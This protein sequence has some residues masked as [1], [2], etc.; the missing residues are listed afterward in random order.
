MKKPIL[1]FAAL[2][3]AFITLVPQKT[4]AGKVIKN[5]IYYDIDFISSESRTGA[6]VSQLGE[7]GQVPGAGNYSDLSGTVTFEESMIYYITPANGETYSVKYA[8]ELIEMYA[9]Q[10]MKN[11]VVHI[12]LPGT[13][14]KIGGYAFRDATALS[15]ISLNEGLT[16]IKTGA[17]QGCTNLLSVNIPTTLTGIPKYCFQ[18]CTSLTNIEITS[19]TTTIIEANAFEGCTNLQS[20]NGGSRLCPVTVIAEE[21]FLDCKNLRVIQLSNMLQSIQKNAFKNCYKL[22][23]ITLPAELLNIGDFAFANSGLTVLANN[24]TTPQI[25]KANVFNGVDLSK[26]T[27]YVPKGCKDAYKAADVWKN[28]GLILEPG[29]TPVEP[30]ATGTQKIGNLYYDLHEDMTA[31][32]LK[33][34]DNM[35]IGGYLTVPANVKYG[36]YTYTVNEMATNCFYKCTKLNS[37][38]LPNTITELE[39]G[40]FAECGNLTAVTLPSG[41]TSIGLYAFQNT[42]ITSV[43]LPPTLT[44]IGSNAFSG[45]KDLKSV[46]V[47]AGISSLPTACFSNCTSLSSV[48]LQEGMTSVGKW[49]FYNCSSLKT[50]K[51][52][53]TVTSLGEEAF[54]SC[55]SLVSIRCLRENPPTANDN[56]FS[57][58]DKSTCILYVPSGTKDA[59]AAAT[60][61]SKF[62]HIQEKGVNEKIKYGKLYYQ[63]EEDGTAYVT[64]ETE[65]ENNYKDLS[66]EITV[67]DKIVYKGFEYKVNAVGENALANCKGITKVNLPLIMDYIRGYAF[68]SCS[69]LAQINIP[70]TVRLLMSTAFEGTQLFND[71]IDADGAVYYDGC[72][73]AGPDKAYAGAYAVK[74]G[75]RLLASN[76]FANRG[77]ITSLT[78]PEGLQCIC[79]FSVFWMDKLNTLSLPSTLYSVGTYFG[80]HCSALKTIYNYSETPVELPSNAFS[81]L[82]K[83]NCTLYVPYGSKDAYS[84]ANIWKDF[85]IMEMDPIY[86]VTFEDY[87]GFE[88]SSEQVKKGGAAT[89]PADPTREGY[90][91]TGWD[92]KFDNVQSDLT[93]KAIYTINAY[94]VTFRDMNPSVILKTESVNY[95]DGAT[96]PDYPEHTGYHFLYWTPEYDVITSD[97]DVYAQYEMNTYTVSF[98]DWDGTELKTF[99]VDH[100]HMINLID[101]PDESSLTREC[102][103]F[104]G[105]KSSADETLTE[106]QIAAAEVMHDETYSAYYEVNTYKLTFVC[107]HGTI[108]LIEGA[109]DPDAVECG[110]KLHFSVTPEEG[111]AFD[112]WSFEYD[113][114]EGYEITD[115]TTITALM[116]ILTYTVTFKDWDGKVLKTETVDY[117]TGA[118]APADPVREG[119]TFTGWDEA[120]DVVTSDLTVTALYE[121][122]AKVYFTVT[123]YDWDMTVLGTEKVEEGHDAKG[124]E[125][126][127]EREGY[128]FTGWNSSL[129]NITSNLNVQAQYEVEKVYFTVTYFDWNMT[130]LGTE[131][132]EE[133]HDA[134][135]LETDPT[136]EGYTF[137]GWSSPLTNITSD[138]NVQAQYEKQEATALD[139]AGTQTSPRKFIENGVLYIYRNGILY[140]PHGQR[141][142]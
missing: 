85:P 80:Y 6:V 76:V 29:E 88:L 100:A 59:Y 22:E 2:C 58:I 82:T 8:T 53:A 121:E 77:E 115:N 101:M 126:D 130:V 110:T 128:T 134:K 61:W 17:F 131:K 136:R 18:G 33:H 72:M 9:F 14:K 27:L 52:P 60:G 103:T 94:T 1:F 112:K 73:L 111:Y 142:D 56:T 132:V 26:C 99:N 39:D 12:I 40:V 107:D 13:V 125:T 48:T 11:H 41:M 108:N 63:L 116:K 113:E 23:K 97:L 51:I 137:T 87:N 37:V 49:A 7:K 133:G 62:A 65:D 44:Q 68:S 10:N 95:G 5:G 20:V 84:A 57:D 42:G 28:F 3:C 15:S 35:N 74:E 140:T 90:H 98:Q 34:D 118:T 32:L 54:Q 92:K 123:Y 38:V 50:I 66:G 117:S 138:L 93:V 102:Y 43:S 69:N 114:L 78:L 70:T 129:E 64:F 47:P 67:E 75:T 141:I 86:T 122:V 83:N 109:V 120:F 30:V 135:G 139:E 81:L 21:A 119:Y 31:K 46:T 4:E 124:L 89:A 105:W 91:F 25:I 104:K 127:P 19:K 79:N 106:E 71:N 36:S 96:A 24:S 55:T 45:C 16:D